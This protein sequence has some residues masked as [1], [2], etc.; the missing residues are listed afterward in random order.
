MLINRKSEWNSLKY[1]LSVLHTEETKII[2]YSREKNCQ[3]TTILGFTVDIPLP[4]SHID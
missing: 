2:N 3:E 1:W 4:A